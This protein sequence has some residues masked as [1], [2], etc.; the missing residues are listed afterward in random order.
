MKGGRGGVVGGG[1]G[2]E[3]GGCGGPV[4]FI[5]GE[6]QQRIAAARSA[7]KVEASAECSQITIPSCVAAT[8]AAAAAW[9]MSL[10]DFDCGRRFLPC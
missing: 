9:T 7:S 1:G 3:G 2:E 5:S 4:A 6:H 8:A 10:C